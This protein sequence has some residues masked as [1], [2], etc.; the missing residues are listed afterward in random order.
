MRLSPDDQTKRDEYREKLLMLSAA[1]FGV[2][3]FRSGPLNEQSRDD[4]ATNSTAD[5]VALLASVEAAM[6]APIAKASKT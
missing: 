3:L 5:A 1:F 2:R 6:D 4:A